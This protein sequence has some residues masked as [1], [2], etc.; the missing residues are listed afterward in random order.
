MNAICGILGKNDSV[1]LRAMAA[2]LKHRGDAR[3]VAEGAD[4]CVASSTPLGERPCLIDGSPRGVSG[5]E[6][7]AKSFSRACAS[8]GGPKE[9]RLRG[10]FAAAARV[11]KDWWLTRDRLGVKPLY[12]AKIDNGLV[13]AS[14]LKALLASGC[15]K[16]RLNLQSVDR[17]L[18][19]R[20][21][22]GPESIIYGARRVQPGHVVLWKNGEASEV[23]A[24]N[25]FDMTIR[26]TT[27]EE[28]A[29]RVGDFL[30]GAVEA[31]SSDALLWSAGIDCAALGARRSGA[32]PVFVSLKTVWQDEAWR[33]RE[34][35]R[36]MGLKLATRKARPLTES[37]FA[38]AAYFLDEPLADA[39]VL[40]LWLIAE[41]SSQFSGSLLSGHGADEM[42]GGYPRYQ[43][44]QKAQGAKGLVPVGVLDEILPALPP[45]AFMRRGGHYLAAIRDNL[46]SY[47]SLLSVFDAEERE[48]LYTEA[49]SAAI[50]E[51]GGSAEALRPYFEND[52]LTRNQLTTWLKIGIP[53]SL[54]TK[55]DRLWAAHGAA[56]EF[57][58][59][60][61]ALVDFAISLPP[62]VKFGVRS[63]P[64]LRQA[65]K[66]VLPGRIRLRARRDFKIPQSGPT[67]R[68]IEN[69]ARDIITQE[70]VDAVGVFRWP[71]VEQILRT[72]THNLYRRR[73]FWALLMFFAWHR[74]FME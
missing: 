5:V 13:F 67:V 33:A 39:S 7:D 50:A 74:A 30:R 51:K 44:L 49:M 59:F 41:Q 17:Y 20:C 8:L 68:V 37:V 65:M 3:H 56:L 40:P 2:A 35:A 31:S 57:P 26:E 71:A 45:N 27:R 46:E 15:I 19:M 53:D 28:A 70:R 36:L 58:Y 72:S 22:P 62:K 12:Y 14:E 61:D 47:L 32:K 54:L 25:E 69:A 24:F 43:F 1:A 23:S 18:T 11:G 63:K 52:D 60:S 48:D 34:S 55:C 38:K 4:Y 42:L 73:Q 64:L 16:K 21:V 9:L 66:G 10:A 29:E 6:L